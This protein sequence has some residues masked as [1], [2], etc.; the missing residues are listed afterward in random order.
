M[1]K[2]IVLTILI[3]MFLFVSCQDKYIMPHIP[4]VTV[5]T[6]AFELHKNLWN[7]C[8]IKN[9]SYTYTLNRYPPLN[10]VVDVTV[11][12]GDISY[13]LKEYNQLKDSEI[14]EI[15]KSYFAS[16]IGDIKNLFLENV[17]NEIELT[18]EE[19]FEDYDKDPDCYYANFDFTFSDDA[20]FILYCKRE[21]SLMKENIDGGSG[22]V[23]IK[24]E[25]FVEN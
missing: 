7:S 2:L 4:G 13:D 8:R 1:K 18:I 23:E 24:I 25:N 14:T 5:D 9:Y 16:E 3:S 22:F 6:E 20:P 21:S 17:F 11:T 15:D 12:N 10:F 19:C